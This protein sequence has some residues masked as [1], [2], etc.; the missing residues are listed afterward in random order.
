MRLHA[1]GDHVAAAALCTDL[2]AC[3]DQLL[4]LLDA[5]QQAALMKIEPL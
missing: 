4:K 2:L 1:A 3:K 5:L